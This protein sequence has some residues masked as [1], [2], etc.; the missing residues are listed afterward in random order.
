MTNCKHRW[1]FV[2]RVYEDNIVDNNANGCYG[3]TFMPIIVSRKYY[4]IWVCNCGAMKKVT[5][6]LEK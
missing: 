4:N 6:R 1:V 3:D 5:E 2:E